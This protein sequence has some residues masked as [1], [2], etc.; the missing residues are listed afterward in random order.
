MLKFQLRHSWKLAIG[1]DRTQR[2]VRTELPIDLLFRNFNVFLSSRRRAY[3]WIFELREVLN[4]SCVTQKIPMIS[5]A[6]FYAVRNAKVFSKVLILSIS[7]S[8]L[9]GLNKTFIEFQPHWGATQVLWKLLKGGRC[10][11]LPY[12]TLRRGRRESTQVLRKPP[13]FS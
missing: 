3:L 13:N 12:G 2:S 8:N 7:K 4:F 11:S 5:L 9:S 6:C 1:L 10:L